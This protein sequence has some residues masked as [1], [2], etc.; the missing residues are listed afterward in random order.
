MA[1]YNMKGLP[2]EHGI[3]TCVTDCT[4]AKEVMQK[5]KLDWT[6]NKCEIV[7]K[8]PFRLNSSEDL[9]AF[10]AGDD[11]D[12]FVHAGN[13]YRDLPNAYATYRTDIMAP[14]GLVKDRYEVVQNMDVFNFFDSAIGKDKAVW[15]YAG[16]MGYGHK[17]FVTAKLPITTTVLGEPIDNYLV[18]SNSH[19]GSSSV[20]VMFTPVRVFCTNCLNAARNSSSVHI[21]LKHTKTVAERLELGSDVLRIACEF[22]VSAKELYDSLTTIKMTDKQV[23]EYLASLQLTEEELITL[24]EID[25]LHGIEK[26]FARDYL[27]MENSGISTRKANQ[28]ATM[29]DYYQNGIAQQS[30]VGTAWG[31]YNAITGYYSN[32]DNKEGTKRLDSLLWGSA[33]NS[34]NKALNHVMEFAA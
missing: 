14:L 8:M 19:D 30:I 12:N 3:G 24:A 13:I 2:W 11:P 26:L 33:N 16:M 21:R 10:M 32:V 6:V 20:D 17:I 18:F 31:A 29:F 15:Q 4:T 27:T 5:A 9:E 25:K 23:M 7:A 34:M 28:L 22:A 1:R